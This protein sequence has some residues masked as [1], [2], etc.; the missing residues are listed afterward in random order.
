MSSSSS[1]ALLAGRRRL[2]CASSTL[3]L[4]AMSGAICVDAVRAEEAPTS[5]HLD[6]I[7]VTGGADAGPGPNLNTPTQ[8]GSRL[9]LTP[10]QT[11]A[12][13]DIISGKTMQDRG[14]TNVE[15]AIV[16]NATGITFLGSPGN[17]GTSL[18]MRG[19]AGLGSVT[20]LY[21][22]TRL[23]PGSGTISFPFD[24][25]GVERIEV[26]R[27]P[28]SVLYGEGAIGGAINV[29]P[30]KP[31]FDRRRNEAMATIGSYGMYGVGLSSAGPVNDRVAYSLNVAG[32]GTNGWM[33]RG[34]AK[35]LAFSG[36]IAWKVN[37]DLQ[38]TLSQDY[39]H[40]DQSPYFGTPLVNNAMLSSL[41]KR[42]FNI[43]D[44]VERYKDN[45]TQIHARWTPTDNVVVNS[46]T[47]YLSSQRDWRNVENYAWRGATQSVARSSYIAIRHDLEQVGNRTDA[48]ITSDIF[49]MKNQTVIGF[50]VNRIDF[51]NSNN[52]PYAGAS[53]VPLFGGA[54]GQFGA[55]PLKTTLDSRTEQYSLFADNRLQVNDQIAVV[56]G[57]R[58]DSPRL[59]RDNPATG[60]SFTRTFDSLNWRLG[61]VW[62]PVQNLAVYAQY[63][64]AS[65]PLGNILSLADSQKDLKLPQGQQIEAGVKATFLDGRGEATFSAYHIVKTDML[66][67]DPLDYTI[68]RQVGQQS[69]QGVE[70][71]IG[72]DLGHGLR[73]DANGVMLRAQ[74][75]DYIQGG[76]DFTGKTPPNVPRRTANVWAS[77]TF[78]EHWT[79]LAGVQY[80]GKTWV[81]DANTMW[82][83]AYTVVNA[84]LRW[85]PHEMMQL[86]FNIYN[87]FDE[88]YATSGSTTQWRLGAPRTAALTLRMS[89]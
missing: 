31:L 32:R 65:E 59:R 53:N 46:R 85:K 33:E 83:P 5:V 81:N 47:Y 41:R 1:L 43:A 84:G 64:K 3:V 86:D 61:L 49:G 29:I 76:G 38:L 26:L 60:D 21:D 34:D 63:S 13:V 44:D 12:S 6:T 35:T 10:M 52:S 71:A 17:G 67:R 57:L 89:F 77:W 78:L 11:P 66:A 2:L 87:L 14:Q 8:A 20:R 51:K 56:G 24:T 62:T 4:V 88:L 7:S 79:V 73:I 37:E 36:A 45:F 75:D 72:F 70:A 25:W 39:G 42:N 16:Q 27:G 30:R 23:Y 50:D 40:N 55:Y 58:Y 9:G 28:A 15:Q 19:F 68:V 22:G 69:S 48:T 82:R 18:A 74:Y 54:P 80:V